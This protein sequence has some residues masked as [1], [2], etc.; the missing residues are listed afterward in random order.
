MDDPYSYFLIYILFYIQCILDY[1]SL[2]L[3]PRSRICYALFSL[4]KI[5]KLFRTSYV[6]R[7]NK[8]YIIEKI[9]IQK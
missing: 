3:L 5:I 8:E 1:E 9:R 2:P 6:R 7:I 4:D